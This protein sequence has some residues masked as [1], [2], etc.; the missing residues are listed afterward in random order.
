[1]PLYET[2][3]RLKV[4]RE[5]NPPPQELYMGLGWDENR[6]TNRRHYRHFYN[7]ELE[8]VKELIPYPSP[9]STYPL[10]KG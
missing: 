3:P 6:E 10:K 5:V 9:F 8:F 7:D 1:M 4:D 2:D